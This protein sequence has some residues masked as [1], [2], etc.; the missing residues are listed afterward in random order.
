MP[1]NE[2]FCKEKFDKSKMPPEIG[3]QESKKFNQCWSLLFST[4]VF[5]Q[6]KRVIEI[7]E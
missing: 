5:P 1:L 4:S 7:S 3:K 2:E 6:H